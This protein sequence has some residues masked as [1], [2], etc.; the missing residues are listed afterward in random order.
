MAIDKFFFNSKKATSESVG[1]GGSSTGGGGSSVN[2]Y[3]DGVSFNPADGILSLSR[4]GLSGLS[5]SLDGRYLTSESDTLQSVTDRGN[6]TT[7]NISASNLYALGGAMQVGQFNVATSIFSMQGNYDNR[8]VSSGGIAPLSF[9]MGVDE[10]ARFETDNSFSLFYDLNSSANI[11]AFNMYASGSNSLQWRTGYEQSVSDFTFNSSTGELTIERQVASNDTVQ[12][13][14]RYTPS[15]DL[16]IA[17]WDSAYDDSVEAFYFSSTTGNLTLERRVS[18]NFVVNLDNRYALIS[19]LATVA[20]SGD[21]NDLINQPFIPST[22]TDIT[23]GLNLYFTNERAQD[24]IGAAFSAGT[25]TRISIG[26]DDANN[27]FNFTVD[28]DLS[29]YDNS[30]TQFITSSALNGYATESWVASQG[31]ALASSLATVATSGSYGD[32]T[33]KPTI[34]TNNNQLTNGAGYITNAA[35]S[36][37]ATE[38]WVN[39][40]GYVTSAVLEDVAYNNIDNFFPETSFTG[41]INFSETGTGNKVFRILT[42]HYTNTEEQVPII[43]AANY[44]NRNSLF[45]GGGS[46]AYNSVTEHIFFV[47]ATPTTLSGTEILAI[48]SSGLTVNNGDITLVGSDTDSVFR[49]Y[50]NFSSNAVGFLLRNQAGSTVIQA[51]ANSGEVTA[52]SFLTP[53]H[54][55]SS[56]WKAAYDWVDTNSANVAYNNIDNA[57]P[58]TNFTGNVNAPSFSTGGITIDESSDR[59]GLLSIS[60]DGG[61]IWAGYSIDF[62]GQFWSLMARDTDIGLYDDTN[63]EWGFRYFVNGG[64]QLFHNG[65]NV[66]ETVSGGVSVT[67]T[68][69]TNSHGTSTD[70]KS[71]YDYSQIGHLTAN[72]TI[73]LSGDLTGSGSTSINATISSNAVEASM[74]NDNIISG[75]TALTSGLAST[76][77]LMISDNGTIKKM[78]VSVLQSYM[79]SSLSFPDT[80]NYLS[81]LSFNTGNGVLTAGRAGLSSLTVDLDGRYSTVNYYVSSASFNTTNGILT[82][83]RSGLAD[84]TVDLDGRYQQSGIE[85]TLEDTATFTQIATQNI[86]AQFEVSSEGTYEVSGMIWMNAS[87]AGR[88]IFYIGTSTASPTSTNRLPPNT[89]A[90]YENGSSG[91]NPSPLFFN[92]RVT[93]SAG[94]NYIIFINLNT[95]NGEPYASLNE[96]DLTVRL[97]NSYIKVIKV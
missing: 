26:Y 15:S 68:V 94:T 17:E 67:G 33:D 73:T 81:S 87:Q 65:S 9:W 37:Y 95:G 12:L 69:I 10:T 18:T 6:T 85:G 23:E 75:L 35:L 86:R 76:D 42:S 19:G 3:V 50:R 43:S 80:N 21:Y 70:W 88:G 31:Y 29:S 74:L 16:S 56:N 47:G 46:G 55:N 28:D 4:L 90:V 45:Y 96:E 41:N 51:N 1:A 11:S 34:P 20:T 82:L 64:I 24:A 97:V 8:I 93:L 61:N 71:A 59:A 89:T 58:A 5:A 44:S 36:G 30:I 7:N 2:N 39:S 78:D 52:A 38:S 79:Q 57:F 66:F 63:N 13:D 84:L 27:R 14:D 60:R 53:S 83:G 25:T 72:Q 54:G 77:E 91:S 92:Y 49:V 48:D 22:T 62:D 32:L 40:Q